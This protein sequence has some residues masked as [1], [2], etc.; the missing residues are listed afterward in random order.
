MTFENSGAV[1]PDVG[2]PRAGRAGTPR[3][4]GYRRLRLDR[5]PTPCCASG[6]AARR[7]RRGLDVVTDRAGNLWAW[8]ADPDAGGP[9]LVAGSHLDSVPDGG[10]F[11]G[12]L[13]VVSA[14]AALDELRARG[15][16]PRR[17]LGVAVLRRRGGRPVRRRLRRAPGCSPARSTPTGPAR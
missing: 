16:A 4:G 1:R 8:W 17:P 2:R 15:V 11:D 5:R 12:P 7:E 9:G 14:F 13:G 10:A 6:S 3:T